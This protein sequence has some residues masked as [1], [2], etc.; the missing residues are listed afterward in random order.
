M[1]LDLV[2][3][4][5]V[6]IF[7]LDPGLD[8]RH[9]FL[10]GLAA[11]VN[12]ALRTRAGEVDL[13]RMAAALAQTGSVVRAGLDW[14]AARGKVEIVEKGDAIWRL[15]LANGQTEGNGQPLALARLDALL[16]ETAAYRDYL[17]RAPESALVKLLS[18]GRQASP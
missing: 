4:E 7:A 1:A 8:E 10:E 16:A 17:R 15:A 18:E 12:Y 5:E 11:R 3:P 13:D 6:L 9:T 14:L 2:Q